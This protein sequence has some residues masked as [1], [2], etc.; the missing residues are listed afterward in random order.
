M[1]GKC[2]I[3]EYDEVL[4]V[5]HELELGVP[6]GSGADW[7]AR[8]AHWGDLQARPGSAIPA[9]VTQPNATVPV[10]ERVT[11]HGALP[12]GPLAA[13]SFTWGFQEPWGTGLVFNT[14]IESAGKP[15]WRDSMEH[16]RCIIPARSFFETSA[17]ET[18]PSPRTGR[19]VKRAYEFTVPGSPVALIGAVWKDGRL[20]MVTTEANRWMAPVHHR[21]PLVIRQEEL[22]VWFGPDYRQLAD[23]SSVELAPA[24]EQPGAV[25]AL[26]NP[27]SGSALGSVRDSEVGGSP[28]PGT[29]TP[30]F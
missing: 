10:A 18:V 26:L 29:M 9:I 25:S 23:R 12:T 7:P 1:C 15:L 8:P 17:T 21:M 20:S 22:P 16:R 2:I 14:R 3:L 27:A 28:A 5:I 13:A 19:P 11:G 24:P 30:L 4:D 6:V